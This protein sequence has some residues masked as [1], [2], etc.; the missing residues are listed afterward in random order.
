MSPEV[1]GF[2][3]CLFGGALLVLIVTPKDNSKRIGYVEEEP[4]LFEKKKTTLLL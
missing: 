2:V 3:L 4:D 1:I